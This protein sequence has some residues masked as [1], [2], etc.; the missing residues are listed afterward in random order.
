MKNLFE[1]ATVEELNQRLPLLQPE[2]KRLWGKMNAAQ[3]LAH[4]SAWME[5]AAGLQSPPRSVIGRIFRPLTKKTVL[6]EKPVR[7]NMP[8]DKSLIVTGERE[9]AVERQQL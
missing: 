1:A 7:R 9:F 2:S 5:M 6:N 8:S 4:C 3:M